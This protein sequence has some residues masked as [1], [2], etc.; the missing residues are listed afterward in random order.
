MVSET[1]GIKSKHNQARALVAQMTL[2]EKAQLCSGKNFWFLESVERL[3]LPS[4]MVTDGPHGLRKQNRQADHVGLNKSVPATCF[5][6]ASALASSWDVDLL[7]QV[8]V[9]LGNNAWRKM[10]PCSW[11]RA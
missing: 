9:A 5:P 2:Q 10:S 4:V 8:G 3:D 11:G 1:A 6:T 7:E